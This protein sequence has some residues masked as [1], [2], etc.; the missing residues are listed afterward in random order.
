MQYKFTTKQD[1]SDFASG[2]VISSI[3][4]IPAFPVRLMDEIFQ[5]CFSELNQ[6][7]PITIY[8]PCCG[9]AYHLTALTFLHIDKI[10][11]IFCS[12]VNEE[13][14]SVAIENM[15]LLALDGM[16]AKIAKL[17]SMYE[18]YGKESHREALESA[19]RLKTILQDCHSLPQTRI[20]PNDILNPEFP[21]ELSD[22]HLDLI[23]VDS[24]YG[25][26]SEWE[27]VY[28][29]IDPI[30]QLLDNIL[31][32]IDDRTLVVIVN[33]NRNPIRHERFFQIKKMKSGKRIT[34]IF[35]KKN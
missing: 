15:Q 1:L 30:I 7:Q 4:Y 11:K 29:E 32:I 5:F 8:D 13:I 3:P 12:D 21:S 31:D 2:K 34:R 24:P 35:R 26:I 28:F 6:D 16:N 27:N 20:F 33:T 23:F 19:A 14:L 10:G 9:S 17:Q 25:R 22:S 18:R